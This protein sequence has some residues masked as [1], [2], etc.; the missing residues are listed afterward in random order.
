[1]VGEGAVEMSRTPSK[2]LRR[3]L[4][5][6]QKWVRYLTVAQKLVRY[7]TVAQKWVRYLTVAQK[8]DI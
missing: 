6:A 1:M 3:F 2:L 7:L 5:V 8:L 4:T